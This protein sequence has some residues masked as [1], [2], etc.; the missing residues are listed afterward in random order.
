[1]NKNATGLILIVLAVGTYFTFTR[2]KIDEIKAIKTVND[3]Y[4]N[5]LVN[6][7]RLVKDRD[8]ILAVYNQIPV[9]DQERLEK[10]IPNNVDNVRLI[11]D[12]NGVASRHG[13]AV[14]NIK[15][16]TQSSTSN[17]DVGAPQTN[18]G[19]NTVTLNFDVSADYRTFLAFLKDLEASLRILEISKVSLKASDTG[20]YDYSLELKTFWLKQ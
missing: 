8:A 2:V 1:M 3:E 14:K 20:V 17:N 12:I 5:A 4:K 6:S 16:T 13:L 15:T 7:E 10:I 9:E 11:I 18:Q 19:Y